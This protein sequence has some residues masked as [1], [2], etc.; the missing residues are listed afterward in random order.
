MLNLRA[1]LYSAAL[2]LLC[3]KALS[4]LGLLLREPLGMQLEVLYAFALVTDIAV[5]FTR[6]AGP[7]PGPFCPLSAP[8]G[9][10]TIR[11]EEESSSGGGGGG[12]GFS[13]S[14]GSSGG[15]A[16]V[17]GVSRLVASGAFSASVAAACP[18]P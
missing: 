10:L 3:S 5:A 11:L 7:A 4:A 17:V 1:D 14:S 12:G 15:S 13:S 6:R 9:L 18:P 8:R 2:P 16:S